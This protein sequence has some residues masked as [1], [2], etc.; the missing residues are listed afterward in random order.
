[1]GPDNDKKLWRRSRS[2]DVLLLL[3]N[4]LVQVGCF[5]FPCSVLAQPQA[6]CN[7][8]RPLS[9]I[10]CHI[11]LQIQ[12]H[13]K[14][15]TLTTSICFSIQTQIASQGGAHLVLSCNWYEIYTK[16]AP[17]SPISSIWS[18]LVPGEL[19]AV[20]VRFCQ[21]SS[22]GCKCLLPLATPKM[23]PSLSLFFVCFHPKGIEQVR[24]LET[25][26]F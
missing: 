3:L 19:C 20:S 15:R 6:T 12:F 23:L 10:L 1:M 7:N 5:W 9:I 8:P 2:G 13:K 17:R 16:I 22:Q 25:S 24:T 26:R 4:G 18:G 14:P 21:T 11:Y